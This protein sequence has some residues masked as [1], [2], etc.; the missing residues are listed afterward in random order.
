MSELKILCIHCADTHPDYRVDKGILEQWH[1][2]PRDIWENDRI[3]GVKY[4]DGIYPD[5][6]H[7]PNQ[8]IDQRSIRELHGRGWN[9]LG[10]S[11]LIHR[12]GDIENLTPYDDD[13]YISSDEMTWGVVGI[14][15]MARHVCLEGGRNSEN[16]SRVF[17]F[18]EIFTDAQFIT[19]V[20]YIKQF[21]KDHPGDKI[22]GH[23]MFSGKTCPNF[24]I[25][26]VFGKARINM[27]Y[28]YNI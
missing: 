17:L 13:D 5:R 2:G 20:G 11:D 7:L 26:E 14:N 3:V 25:D 28:L 22:A 1:K 12:N 21:L 10:Y 9:R 6:Q 15:S 18:N 8:L 4:L 19:L 24:I 16:E 23:Y 27:K